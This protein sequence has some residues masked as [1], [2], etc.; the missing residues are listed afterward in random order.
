MSQSTRARTMAAADRAITAHFRLKEFDCRDGTPYPEAWIADRLLPLCE[1]LETL[2][3]I[4]ARPLVVQSGYRTPEYNRK[5]GGARH[6]E[7]CQGR[8]ADL[9]VRGTMSV[10]AL[11]TMIR[12]LIAEGQIPDGGV[13]QY[14]TFVHYDQRPGGHARWHGGRM[15]NIASA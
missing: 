2:R 8:A 5:I 14:P 11:A 4:I 6:S 10:P 3:A 1:A 15:S 7:H 13:G 12:R 9:S